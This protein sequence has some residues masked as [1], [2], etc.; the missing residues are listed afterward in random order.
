MI[1]KKIKLT[2][3]TTLAFVSLA[4]AQDIHFSQLTESP[5]M[6]NPAN[7]GFF[8]GY[9]R[10]ILNYRDQWTAPNSPF[11]TMGASIDADLGMKA[12][13]SAYLGLGGFVFQDVAGTSNWKTFKGDLFLNGIL[14]TSAASRI[15][16]GVGAGYGQNS[17]DLSKLTYGTQ[18]NGTGFS[19]DLPSYEK[20]E[21]QKHN[22]FDMSAGFNFEYDKTKVNFDADN[23]YWFKIGVAVYHINQPALHYNV[24]TESKLAMK[25]VG[26]ISARFDIK[27]TKL[28][29]LP[30]VVYM[31]QGKFNQI[32]LGAYARLRFKEQ[33]KITGYKHEV[34]LWLGCFYRSNDAVIP[35]VLVEI[36]GFNVGL[37]YDYT[38]SNYKLANKGTGGFEI[39]LRWVSLRDGLFK[40]KSELKGGRTGTMGSTPAK[41]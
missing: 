16:L 2:T 10:V 27:N 5:L 25:Y 26:N 20:P 33:T 24:T 30:S 15:A 38:V 21:F 34:A 41:T 23:F 36:F 32:N 19:A 13:K 37:A 12:K 11:K 39:V 40:R 4:T 7:A 9:Q 8:N 29:I 35:Q 1:F 31:S 28:S 22:Y 18:Y 6:V 14:K 3:L 17:A